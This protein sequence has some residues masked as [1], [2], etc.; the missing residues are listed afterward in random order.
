M[1]VGISYAGTYPLKD[2]LKVAKAGDEVG[3]D[4][5]WLAEEFAYRDPMITA[6][7]RGHL[8]RTTRLRNPLFCT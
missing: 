7:G 4:S 8:R 1:A 2:F 6:A 3:L 5:I